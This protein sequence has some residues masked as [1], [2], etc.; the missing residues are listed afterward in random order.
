[1]QGKTLQLPILLPGLALLFLARI[2][3]AK[4]NP[5]GGDD[6]ISAMKVAVDKGKPC[7]FGPIEKHDEKLQVLKSVSLFV[8]CLS[9]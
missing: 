1:M 4:Y 6:E 9:R 7:I 5:V 2:S 8:I 3:S